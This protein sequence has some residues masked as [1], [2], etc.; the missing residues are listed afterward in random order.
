MTWD[1]VRKHL[2]HQWLLVEA[3]KA[4]SENGKRIVEEYSV[5]NVYP[6]WSEAMTAYAGLHRE[7]RDKEFLVLHTDRETVEIEERVYLGLRL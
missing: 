5:W 6:N 3:V 2:P 7:M 4:Y 1:S